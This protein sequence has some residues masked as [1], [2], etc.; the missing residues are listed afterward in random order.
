VPPPANTDNNAAIEF[1]LEVIRDIDIADPAMHSAIEDASVSAGEKL[2]RI[3]T[4]VARYNTYLTNTYMD[5]QYM[6]P[7]VVQ[8]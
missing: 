7:A 4:M 1:A 6:S 8:L 3:D 2:I 5:P